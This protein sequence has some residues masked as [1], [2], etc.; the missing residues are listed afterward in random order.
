[1]HDTRLSHV[2]SPRVRRSDPNQGRE[3][4]FL[5]EGMK[6]FI[7]GTVAGLTCKV[8]EFPFDTV[9]ALGGAGAAA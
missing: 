2:S 7:A 6:W 1:M 8:V 3:V 4:K 9:G 5:G